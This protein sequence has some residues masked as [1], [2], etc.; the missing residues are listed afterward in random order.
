MTRRMAASSEAMID[1]ERLSRAD[2][3]RART[4]S[5]QA[6]SDVAAVAT[7]SEQLLAAIGEISRQAVESTA[8]VRQAV[9]ETNGSSAEMLRLAAAA[10]DRDAVLH[11][12]SLQCNHGT[13]EYHGR[14][15]GRQ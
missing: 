1:Q 4:A 10:K 5:L 15:R 9:S 2:S 3:D 7:A 12:G 14:R 6:A 13:D 11:R 8:V